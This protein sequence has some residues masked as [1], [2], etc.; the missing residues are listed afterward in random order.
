MNIRRI[1]ASLVSLLLFHQVASGQ[2]CVTPS[3]GTLRSSLMSEHNFGAIGF[4]FASRP[5]RTQIVSDKDCYRILVGPDDDTLTLHFFVGHQSA[6]QVARTSFLAA[7]SIKIAGAGAEYGEPVTVGRKGIWYRMEAGTKIEISE[8]IESEIVEEM[9]T[10][11]FRTIHRVASPQRFREAPL[12][13]G[14]RGRY[15]HGK[16]DGATVD[17]RDRLY[18]WAGEI[19]PG[20]NVLVHNQLI[21][22]TAAPA[23]H[24]PS[25][26]Y[27][28]HFSV[29]WYKSIEEVIVRARSPI[30]SAVSREVRFV[31]EKRG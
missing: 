12:L 6:F 27:G 23:D 19:P 14:L 10:H 8:E 17:S 26:Q 9:S 4:S 18:Y 30:S 31:F 28:I 16:P 7:Q 2:E 11:R 29:S 20:K 21:R 3:Y 13:T 22:F 25:A 15:W 24:P 1:V 5:A